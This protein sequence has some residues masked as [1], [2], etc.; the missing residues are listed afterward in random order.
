MLS[1]NTIKSGIREK[2]EYYTEDE[3]LHTENKSPENYY[4]TGETQSQ[5]KRLTQAV[6]YGKG[7][8]QQ[9]LE[10]HIQKQ[11]FKHLFHGFKPGTDERIRAEKPNPDDQERLAEDFTWPAPKSVSMAMHLNQDWRLFDA[12]MESLQECL[13]LL[14]QQYTTTRIQQNGERRI[15]NTDNLT[16]ALIPH[17]TSR[18][19]DMQVH[20]HAVVMN[21]TQGPD[22]VW[23]S[24]HNDAMSQQGWLGHLYRQKLAHK[25]QELGYEIYQTKDGFEL[26][27]LTREDIQGFSKRS[28]A[29]VKHLKQ[30]ELDVTP[31]NR[32]R[33]TLTTRRT[34]QMTQT[35]EECQ[36]GWQAEAKAIGVE[37]PQP[38]KLLSNFWEREVPKTS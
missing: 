27:G 11:D 30:Q 4:S 32:D 37:V 19:G 29:I 36:Q 8:K 6:W 12:H 13:D 17:H 16:I 5:T 10:E 24:L 23:R 20:T 28:R 38:G 26:K 33:A 2:E 7:A 9:G 34:K 18:D 14:E 25:L 3:L 15:I 1:I 31:E 22:G 21:G 35:L